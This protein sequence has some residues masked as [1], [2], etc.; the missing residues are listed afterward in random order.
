MLDVSQNKLT[1][2]LLQRS[3]FSSYANEQDLR[4]NYYG[5]KL[6]HLSF[7]D[8]VQGYIQQRRSSSSA[9]DWN[10]PS[11]DVSFGP[12]RNGPHDSHGKMPGIK[13]FERD[14]GVDSN[15]AKFSVPQALVSPE[16]SE[17]SKEPPL[18]KRKLKPARTVGLDKM[19]EGL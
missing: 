7:A 10:L 15:K 18:K 17:R 1:N 3:S 19:L 9:G 5:R 13:C 11:I 12:R 2:I 6:H 8:L 4:A 14:R 16:S